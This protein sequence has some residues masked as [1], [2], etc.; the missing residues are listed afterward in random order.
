[1]AAHY[2]KR[3]SQKKLALSAVEKLQRPKRL[4]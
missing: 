1:M 2:T 4:A 3:A